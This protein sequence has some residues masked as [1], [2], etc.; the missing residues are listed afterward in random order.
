[1][2]WRT[3]AGGLVKVFPILIA[4]MMKR[5]ENEMENY[6]TSLKQLQIFIERMK[7]SGE[8]Y[9]LHDYIGWFCFYKGV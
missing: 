5:L 8:R 6:V 9:R 4:T 1:V 7:V 3:P 2:A